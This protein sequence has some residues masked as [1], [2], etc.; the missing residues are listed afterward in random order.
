[1]NIEVKRFGKIEYVMRY[2]NGYEEGKRYPVILFLHGSGTRGTDIE[3]VKENSFLTITEQMED[4]PFTVIAPQCC[5]DSWFD[6]HETLI[7][8]VLWLAEQSFVEPKRIYAMGTSMGGYATWQIGMS[9]H[10]YFAAIVPICGAGAYWNAGNLKD[11]GIWAFHGELDDAVFASESIN[12][13]NAIKAA[14]GNDAKLTIFEG[15]G[16]GIWNEVYS[17]P[18]VYSWLLQHKNTG[19]FYTCPKGR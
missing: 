15:K 8:F 3:A 6:L 13:V 4:F 11:M 1:M 16:H 14:G 9:L 18:E 12:M 7:D 17:N 2:P 5:R 10:E 19:E